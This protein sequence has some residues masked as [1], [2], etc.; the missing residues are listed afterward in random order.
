M[1]TDTGNGNGNDNDNNGN[2]NGGGGGEMKHYHRWMINEMPL[3]IWDMIGTCLTL[4]ERLIIMERIN[5]MCYNN[6]LN[7]CGWT[8]MK[9]LDLSFIHLLSSSSSSSSSS[10]I[11]TFDNIIK[12]HLGT[13]TRLKHCR[14]I[15]RLIT[16]NMGGSELFNNNNGNTPSRVWSGP[17]S[18]SSSQQQPPPPPPPPSLWSSLH[19]L[20][21]ITSYTVSDAKWLTY[22]PS[23]TSL[24]IFPLAISNPNQTIGLPSLPYLRRL[25]CR[26]PKRSVASTIALSHHLTDDIDPLDNDNNTTR[27]GTLTLHLK[28]LPELDTLI[29]HR[30]CVIASLVRIPHLMELCIHPGANDEWTSTI[31]TKLIEQVG[32][33]R[34]KRWKDANL[35]PSYINYIGVMAP[36]IEHVTLINSLEGCSDLG[37][38]E[39]MN[40]LDESTEMI[41]Y[42]D[43]CNVPVRCV[44]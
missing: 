27:C 39:A 18:S 38:I 21:W 34:L 35:R 6:S 13:K 30:D 22:L 32:G 41:H 19:T 11:P 12:K 29:L 28:S 31:W 24:T 9:E 42:M 4:V 7:G 10:S 15:E 5:K 37:S 17:S 14:S 23:L 44:P 20:I 2:G 16:C 36:N 8:Q 25:I 1:S 43:V 40:K 33:P 26:R 3:V